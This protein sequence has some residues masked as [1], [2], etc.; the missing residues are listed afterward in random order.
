MLQSMVNH[1]EALIKNAPYFFFTRNPSK[2]G[3]N[4]NPQFFVSTL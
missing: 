3:G 2:D 4:L 1:F